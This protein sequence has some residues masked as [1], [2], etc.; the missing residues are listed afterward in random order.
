MA[1][2]DAVIDTATIC[3][4]KEPPTNGHL[5]HVA[6]HDQKAPLAQIMPQT[7]FWSNPR[8][9]FNL[10][11]T[12]EKRALWRKLN[13]FPRL[14]DFFAIHEGVHSGNIREELFVDRRIDNT[15]ESLLFGR[16]E[17]QP[18][19]LQWAGKYIRLG[20]LP[21]RRT[22]Q[23][24]ANAGQP[25][26]YY[27]EKVLVRR[28][29]DFVLAA[30]DNEQRYASNN[31]FVVFPKVKHELSLYGLCAL[32]NSN[33]MTWYFR[34]IEPRF[35]RVFAELKIKHLKNFPLPKAAV[36]RIRCLELNQ[37]GAQRAHIAAKLARA[38]PS[39]KK[40]LLG[41]K[42]ALID[43]RI[44]DLIHSLYELPGEYLV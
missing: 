14:G 25:A 18:F 39:R 26:W 38:S 11:L 36:E 44:Q 24:Y 28:T 23:R 1:F 34:T 19:H 10:H 15:C 8:H 40:S 43:A 31:F 21:T 5:V 16:S 32:L 35:G 22:R 33:F 37:L 6:V 27:R 41:Q 12:S 13:D 7:D 30:I 2:S 17:I 9:V 29:G 42:A 20:A 3:G 4:V